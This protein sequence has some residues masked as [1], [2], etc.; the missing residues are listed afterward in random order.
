M[1]DTAELVISPDDP[2]LA[3]P[4]AL[5]MLRQTRALDPYGV[6]DGMSIA[7]ILDPFIVTKERAREI[8]VVGDPDDIT[9]A[10]IKAYY[11]GLSCLIEQ[12]T[13]LMATP[14]VN[15]SHEGFGRALIVVGSLVVLY[16]TLR[17]VHRF[18]FR[19][20]DK[21]VQD[22]DQIVTRS[23]GLIEQFPDVARL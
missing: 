10:R 13:G 3:H 17:D 1:N 14:I 23:A 22:A 12:R 7:A 16:K 21:L 20:L 2:L 19:S 15:L 8:P 6:Y 5:E 11:N 4:V 18:G 9:L